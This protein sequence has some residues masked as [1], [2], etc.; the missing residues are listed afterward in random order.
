MMTMGIH[1]DLF[2]SDDIQQQHE[3]MSFSSFDIEVKSIVDEL[4]SNTLRSVLNAIGA[5][6]Q[7]LS[8]TI[9][10]DNNILTEHLASI[11]NWHHQ[12]STINE[13]LSDPFDS[14][15]SHHFETPD[16][17]NPIYSNIF[18]ESNLFHATLNPT[19][20]IQEIM[21]SPLLMNPFDSTFTPD[22]FMKNPFTS[23]VRNLHMGDNSIFQADFT[24]YNV[25]N[26]YN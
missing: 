18:D 24:L 5:S 20:H 17:Q 3:N 25:I 26:Y 2:P 23:S 11:I 21:P 13:Q 15:W 6:D 14:V 4:V 9:H 1:Q 7:T 16:D 8:E 22:D 12:Q 19:S 10:E